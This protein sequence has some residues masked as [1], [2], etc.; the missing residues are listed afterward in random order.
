MRPNAYNRFPLLSSAM[1]IRTVK[2]TSLLSDVSLNCHRHLALQAINCLLHT[3]P[4]STKLQINLSFS[5]KISLTM[6]Q[7]LQHHLAL[8]NDD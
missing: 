2:K 1:N 8:L 3:R 6:I 4:P 7:P 5:K